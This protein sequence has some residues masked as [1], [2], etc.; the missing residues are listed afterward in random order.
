MTSNARRTGAVVGAASVLALAGYSIG[1]AAGDGSAVAAR[2]SSERTADRPGRFDLEAVADELGVSVEALRDALEDLRESRRLGDR[3]AMLAAELAE[4]LGISEERVS[5]ALEAQHDARAD[6]FAA[7]LAEALDLEAAEVRAAL[8]E[9]RP[10]PGDRRSRRGPRAF[11]GALASELGVSR[12]KLRAALREVRSE[13]GG[14]RHAGPDVAALADALGVSEEQLEDAFDEIRENADERR[15]QRHEE[16]IEA[17]AE[18]LGV[19]ADAVREALPERPAGGP[20]RHHRFGPG[21]PGFG[22]GG[23]GSGP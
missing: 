13:R 16:F 6:A 12:A 23:P 20:G 19:S 8:D 1:S 22:S 15:E 9:V 14:E 5:E 4:A 7:D 10:Q 11:D 2:D 17:L 18:R 3:H 21:R